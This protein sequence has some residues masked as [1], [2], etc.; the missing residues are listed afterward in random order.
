MKDKREFQGGKP[1]KCQMPQRSWEGKREK[2][3]IRYSDLKVILVYGTIIYVVGVEGSHKCHR[4]Q[5]GIFVQTARGCVSDTKV[6][7]KVDHLLE[8]SK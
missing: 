3:S 7:C 5:N 6:N 4:I 8:I 2:K 1:Q